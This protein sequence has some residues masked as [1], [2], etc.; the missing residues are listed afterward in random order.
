M[1]KVLYSKG[2][3]S[4]EKYKALR[5]SLSMSSNKKRKGRVSYKFFENVAIPKLLPYDKLVKYIDSLH[6]G[7]VKSFSDFCQ[8]Q[9][10]DDCDPCEWCI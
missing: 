3:L 9:G 4:K 8:T 10:V 1:V 6:V 5:L 2:L 7:G